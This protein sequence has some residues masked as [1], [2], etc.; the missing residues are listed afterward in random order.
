M[1]LVKW[2]D[3]VL[4][5]VCERVEEVTPELVQRIQEMCA[6]CQTHKGAGLAA[7]QVGIAK[8]I[9]VWQRVRGHGT[10]QRF[11]GRCGVAINPEIEPYGSEESYREGCLSFP[12]FFFDVVRPSRCKMEYTDV[13]GKTGS[14]DVGGLTARVLQH[15]YDHLEGRLIIDHEGAL[16]EWKLTPAGR[17]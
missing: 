5:E 17:R 1:N 2:N 12:K 9:I 13:L 6:L 15:E 3:P 11:T 8:R 4:R 7:P 14:I 16:D 10:R